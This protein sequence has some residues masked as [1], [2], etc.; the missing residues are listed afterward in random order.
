MA[1]IEPLRNSIYSI[2]TFLKGEYEEFGFVIE[3]AILFPSGEH[4]AVM[5]RLEDDSRFLHVFNTEGTIMPGW[6]KGISIPCAD[7]AILFPGRNGLA[8]FTKCAPGKVTIYP[9]V[10]KDPEGESITVTFSKLP[11]YVN[12]TP[13]GRLLFFGDHHLEYF[14]PEGLG[15]VKI[16]TPPNGYAYIH[17]VVDSKE[18]LYMLYTWRNEGKQRLM[19]GRIKIPV[20]PYYSPREFWNGIE[21]VSAAS[22]VLGSGKPV[23]DLYLQEDGSFV[24][25]LGTKGG[26]EIYLLTPS[27]TGVVLIP[28]ELI[29]LRFTS[30]GLFLITGVYGGSISAG[31]VPLERLL[32]SREIGR[33]DLEGVFSL[34]RYVPSVV[35]PKYAG[36]SD[37]CEILYLGR[38]AYRAAGQKHYYYLRRDV[39]Y[40]YRIRW[41]TGSEEREEAEA[42]EEE[43]N[44]EEVG[45]IRTLLRRFRQ[46][47]LYGPP[48]TGKTYLA[49]KV[50]I[51]P[52]FVSFHQSFSYEDFVEGFRP[53][54]GRDG[55]VYDVV[56]GVF[57]RTAVEA[58]YDSLPEKFRRRNATYAEKKRAVL[59]FLERRKA[60]EKVKLTPRREFYLVI[61]EINRGNI[62]R[63]FG[64]LIT[65]LDP[66]KR[67]DGPNE[68][69]MRL[70]YSGELFA[71]PPNLYIIG[72]MNSADRSIALL[73]IALRRRFAFY[74][75]LPRPELLSGMGVGGVNLEHL[76]SRLNAIIEREKGKDYTIGHGYFM[77]I[78]SSENPEEDL[79]LVFYHKILPLFQEYF[80]GNWEQLGSFYP[81]F[82]FIDDRGRI[83]KMDQKSFM[84]ALRRLVRVE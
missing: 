45:S 4:M 26:R 12:F 61:D 27:R 1:S 52:E 11:L 35:D 69:I 6:E 79:Y 56:D 39:D 5:V 14:A 50:A 62:S 71:V 80:Y 44:A 59:D 2:N 21:T 30:R 3:E 10:A 49:R 66:D 41:E 24:A 23:G 82:E 57:K 29:Y 47:I 55:V 54:K 53:A 19:V 74:E 7:E 15:V 70:P 51:K 22:M 13:E 42:R 37:D 9:V 65:L 73:D 43:E 20:F 16:P 76:L 34:G 31:I 18:A 48:G 33:D 32:E 46:V 36:V 77:D 68:T 17:T 8:V 58:I 40:L 83:V 38:T 67:L 28:G 60:G 84:E 81:G 75:V 63:I 64:E 25:V 78:A 72:T